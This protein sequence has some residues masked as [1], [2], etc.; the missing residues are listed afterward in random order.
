MRTL[1]YI[2]GLLIALGVSLIVRAETADDFLKAYFQI[3]DGDAAEKGGESAKA[4]EK[5]SAALKILRDIKRA[6]PNWNPNI[7]AYR[8]KYC[9]DHIQKGGGQVPPEEAAPAPP[10]GVPSAP[11]TEAAPTAVDTVPPGATPP[12]EDTPPP[13]MRP[14]ERIA[15]LEKELQE[16]R[17]EVQRL[18][19]EKESLENRL[20][21]AEDDLK[22]A[23]SAHDDLQKLKQEKESLENRL[24]KAEED[25]KSS[26]SAS[27]ERVQALLKENNSLKE[28]LAETETKLKEA[29]A[30][31]Q[32]QTAALKADLEK[33]QAALEA[34]KKEGAD[35]RA[36]NET[37]KKE[38]EETRVQLKTAQE[39]PAATVVP[40]TFQML[41]K[42]NALLR[43]IVDRQ[44][45]EDGKRIAARDAMTQELKDLGSKTDALR[46]QLEILQTPLTPLSDEERQ[47]LKTP[48]ATL[49]PGSDDPS[50][51]KGVVKRNETGDHGAKLTGENAALAAEAKALF[52]KSDIAGAAAK[53]EQ[54]LQNAPDNLVAL[55]N[56]GVIRFRQG[57]LPEAEK[58]L[59]A[60]LAI[61][62]Q[63]AFS[64]SVLG[65]VFFKQNRLDEAVGAL[66][67]AIAINSSNHETHN[68]L[69]ITYSSKG[70]QEAAEKELIKA[71][72]LKPDYADAHFNLAVVYASQTP[73]SVELA[74]KHYKKSLELGMDKDPELEKLLSK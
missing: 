13:A 5:Y 44:F 6:D 2:S 61:E 12:K 69:G 40:E 52:I 26:S 53:Y 35:L 58:A 7:I 73:P 50:K 55:S 36:S 67:Q 8:S 25:L 3:Q 38:L 46:A 18:K 43:S 24:K 68:Y 16:A 15:N 47:L 41:Q 23:T 22:S 19:Q 42:E 21:K 57:Q 72:E 63:D 49:R 64:L 9:A 33:A 59:K 39:G 30:G 45:Q 1:L 29:T 28:K 51:L 66:T 70:Y 32:E 20:K 37:L 62:Q 14:S 65:I 74:R 11:T 60:A 54:I 27:D 34:A 10:P 17:E 71:V 48:P 56:L 31:T 4:V